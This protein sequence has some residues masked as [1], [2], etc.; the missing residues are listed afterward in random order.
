MS[1]AAS[2]VL[3]DVRALAIASVV[4]GPP[5]AYLLTADGVVRLVLE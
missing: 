2:G 5:I 3:D 1:G 4:D